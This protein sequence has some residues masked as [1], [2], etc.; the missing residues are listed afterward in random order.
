M[1]LR[2]P[3]GVLSNGIRGDAALC[4][5]WMP[6]VDS[7]HRR[8]R[9][10]SWERAGGVVRQRGLRRPCPHRAGC[11]RPASLPTAGGARIDPGVIEYTPQYPLWTDGAAKRRW[12]RLPPGEAVDASD[13]DHFDFPPG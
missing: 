9:S 4:P 12:L 11:R 13:P 1:A 10:R 8:L 2:T 6:W 7:L 3:E 5:A